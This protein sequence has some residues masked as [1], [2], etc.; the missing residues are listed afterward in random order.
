MT[1]LPEDLVEGRPGEWM[2]TST[3]RKFFP[4][5]PRPEDFTISDIANG[6][7]LDGRYGGQGRVDRFYSVA[8]H[9]Y[10]IAE[11]IAKH[12]D[13]GP[14]V[15]LCGLVHDSP[16][17]LLRDQPRAIKKAMRALSTPSPYDTISDR[18]EVVILKKYGLTDAMAANKAFIKELDCRIVPLEKAAIMRRPQEWAYDE[19]E[20]LEGVEIKCLPPVLAK[21]LW[22]GLYHRLC[23]D[24]GIPHEEYEIN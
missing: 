1:K 6:H 16:E 21:K 5:D 12:T 11:Y 24:A 4:L 13:K 7:A 23:V 22:L 17:G 19:F 9:T 2:A 15:A 10:R 18:L 8:E 20:P 14:L 3:G